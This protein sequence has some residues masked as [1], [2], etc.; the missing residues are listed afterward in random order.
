M[1]FSLIESKISKFICSSVL[2]AERPEKEEVKTKLCEKKK[3][4][5]KT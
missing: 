4:T 5:Q 3:F 2:I 1:E